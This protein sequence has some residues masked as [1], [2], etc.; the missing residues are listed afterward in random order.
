MEGRCCLNMG[1]GFLSFFNEVQRVFDS[2]PC[3]TSFVQ[4]QDSGSTKMAGVC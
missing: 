3:L 2:T 4:L 1:F